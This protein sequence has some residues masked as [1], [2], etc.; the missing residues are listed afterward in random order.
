MPTH[1]WA[2]YK[3]SWQRRVVARNLINECASLALVCTTQRGDEYG[4]MAI[5]QWLWV[6]GI[7]G[8]RRRKW[9]DDDDDDGRV[10]MT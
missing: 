5:W 9:F 3:D 10:M 2:T 1:P 8:W 7:T 6:R 4:Y